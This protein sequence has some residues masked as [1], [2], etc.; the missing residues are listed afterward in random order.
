MKYAKIVNG[1]VKATVSGLKPFTGVWL[2]VVKKWECPTEYPSE[3][4]VTNSNVPRMKI[5]GEEVHESWEFTLTTLDLLV[6]EQFGLIAEKRWEL[7][8]AG[9]D[10]EGMTVP[11][12]ATAQVKIPE[13]TTSIEAFKVADGVFISLVDTQP[14]KDALVAHVQRVYKWEMDECDK[15]KAF[16]TH[17]ELAD[18]LYPPVLE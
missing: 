10:F 13:M 16:N 11:A 12:T 1:K 18:Y 14:L 2:P 3:F 9:F 8:V 5:V 15:V 17:K 4:Y 7:E 6:A